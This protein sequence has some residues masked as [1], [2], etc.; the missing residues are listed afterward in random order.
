MQLKAFEFADARMIEYHLQIADSAPVY[1]TSFEEG[2]R[3]R[4]RVQFQCKIKTISDLGRGCNAEVPGEGGRG[5]GEG[6]ISKLQSTFAVCRDDTIE[7]CIVPHV[8]HGGR[9]SYSE[10]LLG[11][12]V[13]PPDVE[14]VE[15]LRC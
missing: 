15:V 7:C 3:M 1:G 10:R 14:D 5:R 13:L 6:S 2:A 11:F 12:A 9:M 4:W 8:G